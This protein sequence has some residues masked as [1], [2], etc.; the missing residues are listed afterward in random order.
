MKQHFENLSGLS[1][2]DVRIHYRSPEPARRQAYAYTQGNQVYIAPGQEKY[3]GHE[4]GHVIQQKQGRVKPSQYRQ[5]E[6]IND[7]AVLEREADALAV[8]AAGMPD[9]PASATLGGGTGERAGRTAP[10]QRT[11]WK[12]LE[13][14]GEWEQEEAEEDGVF[15]S[16]PQEWELD[17]LLED[18]GR[19]KG[20]MKNNSVDTASYEYL[21]WLAEKSWNR[22]GGFIAPTLHSPRTTKHLDGPG[23]KNKLFGM[24]QGGEGARYPREYGEEEDI[25]RFLRWYSTFLSVK[26][27]ISGEIQCY[28]DKRAGRILISTNLGGEI[29]KLKRQLGKVRSDYSAGVTERQKRHMGHMYQIATV[30]ERTGHAVGQISLEVV[31]DSLVGNAHAEQRILHYLKSQPDQ[32]RGAMLQ[33]GVLT[34]EGDSLKLRPEYLGG[35]RRCCFACA[36]ACFTAEDADRVHMGPFWGSK[37]SGTYMEKED[38][39]RAIEGIRIQVRTHVTMHRDGATMDNDTESDMEEDSAEFA[40]EET[41][42]RESGVEFAGGES[43]VRE[44]GTEFAGEEPDE[45]EAEDE[46]D[47][48][49]AHRLGEDFYQRIMGAFFRQ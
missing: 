33:E 4:L 36:Y 18:A 46:M 45:E 14:T 29:Q 9:L 15:S 17:L 19:N 3:L 49:I 5:G 41:G 35:I 37:A 28:Y 2:Q 10:I 32:V 26:Y 30:L 7:S 11:R 43:G 47:T 6:A 22:Y 34:A 23:V 16:A 20:P 21:C 42:A 39:V 1:F 12:Y 25:H 38:I 13:A 48:A 8:A 31:G 27:T 44:S 24:Y 40:G